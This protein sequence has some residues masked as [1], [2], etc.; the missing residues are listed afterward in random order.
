LHLTTTEEEA[1][2]VAG[3]AIHDTGW[4]RVCSYSYTPEWTI[5]AA[6]FCGMTTAEEAELRA[7]RATPEKRR[8]MFGSERQRFRISRSYFIPVEDREVANVGPVVPG[9]KRRR[10]GGWDPHDIAYTPLLGADGRAIGLISFD[11]PVGDC[12]PD[13]A[14][15]RNI[16]FLAD[17]TARVIEQMRT[18]RRLERTE[19]RLAALLESMPN[20]VFYEEGETTE[21]ISG[22]VESLLGVS[23]GEVERAEGG[24]ASF[25]D[26]RDA[27]RV[28][29]RIE[30]WRASGSLGMLIT[31]ARMRAA[32]GKYR[33]IEDRAVRLPADGAGE[34]RAGVMFDVTD[35]MTAEQSL[36]EREER[37]R[38]VTLATR[39]GIYDWNIETDE[40]WRNE[41]VDEI[42]GEL[43]DSPTS[44]WWVKRVHPD[45]AD[46]VSLALRSALESRRDRWDAEYRIRRA[47]GGYAYVQ[48]RGFIK[49]DANGRPIRLIGAMGDI[50]VRKRFEKRQAMMLRELDHRVK[51]NLAA[52]IALAEQTLRSE[53]TLE[54]FGEVFTGRLRALSRTHSVLAESQQKGA[55]LAAIVRQTLE[56]YTLGDAHRL[57]L[58]G[59]E[60]TLPASMAAPIALVFN[61][62]ATNAVKH[63]AM[64]APAGWIG[65][66]WKA[67][68]DE[69]LGRA[70]RIEWTEHS[71]PAVAPPE[72]KSFGMKLIRDE[73]RHQLRGRS[74][75]RF[76]PEGLQCMII[77]PLEPEDANTATQ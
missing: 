3:R 10:D 46:R 13:K 45:D 72:Q 20:V 56:P 18:T 21:L 64:S 26:E 11:D 17:A 28:R 68:Q 24:L 36:R 62:L 71:G 41:G 12:R 16:E 74:E 30:E 70:L 47:G 43:A 60:T 9:R 34:R 52:V 51:N 73:V 27:A 67:T 7:S 42:V 66:A 6:A 4:G 15:F 38:M 14:A 31:R 63:G 55:S 8:F 65:V 69:S 54:A 53:Q 5:A 75:I 76:R 77:T 19:Y 44:D 29:E 49:R 32:D 35:Q 48:D 59:E 61:E 25:L 37:F 33:W 2:D 50:T 40:V 23:A 39:D 57:V 58:S 22:N 1:L